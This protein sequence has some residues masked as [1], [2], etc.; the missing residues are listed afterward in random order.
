MP[1]PSLQLQPLLRPLRQH[2]CCCCCCILL[3]LFLPQGML[4]VPLYGVLSAL[5]L[6]RPK[7]CVNN[8]EE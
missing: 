8:R 7:A 3:L 5:K 2:R 6:F 4:T 1:L